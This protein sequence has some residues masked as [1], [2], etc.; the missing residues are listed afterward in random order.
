MGCMTRCDGSS[1][2]SPSLF[3][4]RIW[5]SLEWRKLLI[6]HN[7]RIHTQSYV[8]LTAEIRWEPTS[9]W[10]QDINRLKISVPKSQ[11]QMLHLST[12]G[13]LCIQRGEFYRMSF[14]AT[15]SSTLSTSATDCSYTAW[16]QPALRKKKKLQYI[17]F[18]KRHCIPIKMN[19]S[20]HFCIS[21]VIFKSTISP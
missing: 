5:W 1:S 7:Q 2:P 6:I 19:K 14:L 4:P 16:A 3:T 11:F 12:K 15:H 18:F 8:Q 17:H 20:C 9:V 13:G 10:W 21:H